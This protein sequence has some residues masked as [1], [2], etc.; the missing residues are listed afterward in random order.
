MNQAG[1]RPVRL[2][3]SDRLPAIDGIRAVAIVMV[4]VSH[5]EGIEPFVKVG[6]MGVTVFFVLSGFLITRLLLTERDRTG[7][8]GLGR[9]YLRRAARLFPA[10]F[11]MVAVV[12]ALRWNVEE[13]ALS[14]AVWSIS[15]VG[16]WWSAFGDGMGALDHVWSL[17][18]EEQFYLTWPLV[19]LVPLKRHWLL[20]MAL[21]ML[22]ATV[23]LNALWPY[24][25]PASGM[26][27][28][29]HATPFQAP[30]ILSGVILAFLP[31]PKISRLGPAITVTAIALLVFIA[32]RSSGE[33]WNRYAELIA[34]LPAAVMVVAAVSGGVL[35]IAPLPYVGRVSYSLYLWHVPLFWITDWPPWL[36]IAVSVAAAIAS[37]HVVERPFLRV[38]S[39]F[40][41]AREVASGF[42]SSR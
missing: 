1:A 22:A 9:F 13:R 5:G 10:L 21:I 33:Q 6:V 20:A 16:N 28:F 39:Q 19:L 36:V 42:A 2:S 30:A 31:M 15:Y 32:T 27:L 34:A 23:A 12:T 24:Q 35:A 3:T 25:E 26:R 29:G 38:A 4:V 41:R 40:V 37:Y 14:D 17:A 18:V 8:L 7:H 11:L